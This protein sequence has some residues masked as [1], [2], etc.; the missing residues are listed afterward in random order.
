MSSTVAASIAFLRS[1]SYRRADAGCRNRSG[2]SRRGCLDTPR[3]TTRRR[4]PE[5]P[6]QLRDRF[7]GA[8]VIGVRD[9]HQ[10]SIRAR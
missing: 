1:L 8:V 2:E 9:A 4:A 10:L 5:L 6:R 7:V 3:S